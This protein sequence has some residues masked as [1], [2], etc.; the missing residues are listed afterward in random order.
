M[1]G[2]Y[3]GYTPSDRAFPLKA[4]DMNS[5]IQAVFIGCVDA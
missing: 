4:L 2:G 5:N 1:H 3:S